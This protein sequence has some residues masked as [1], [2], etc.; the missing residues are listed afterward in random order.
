MSTTTSHSDR[1]F[2]Y[3]S[4]VAVLLGLLI[5]G[6]GLTL[7]S[8]TALGGGWIAATGL[9]VALRGL[10]STVWAGRRFGLSDA[11]RRTLT[12]SSVGLATVLS[13][14]FVVIIL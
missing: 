14:A 2:G 12:L 6:Y 8:E 1:S 11:D 10:F 7:L 9:S 4:I 5:V 13:V 3:T